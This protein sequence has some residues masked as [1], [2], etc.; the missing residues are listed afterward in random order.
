M[1][2]AARA[3]TSR[4]ATIITAGLTASSRIHDPPHQPCRPIDLEHMNRQ[5]AQVAER[6]VACADMGVRLAV[7]DFAPW[8]ALTSRSNGP[9]TDSGGPMTGGPGRMFAFRGTNE[10]RK[11]RFV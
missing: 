9:I 7:D 3:R 6:Q 2:L 5:P 1:G 4:P 8:V 10:I 11:R